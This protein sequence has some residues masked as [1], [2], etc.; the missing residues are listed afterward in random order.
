MEALGLALELHEGTAG[1]A[2]GGAEELM[3]PPPPPAMDDPSDPPPSIDS[4]FRSPVVSRQS[5]SSP[6]PTYSQPTELPCLSTS[7]PP[8]QDRSSDGHAPP[9]YLIPDNE[10]GGEHV[11]RPPPYMDLMPSE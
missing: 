9:P 2:G 6:H 3:L 11:M 8:A 7:P 1:G 5:P 10:R 4:D